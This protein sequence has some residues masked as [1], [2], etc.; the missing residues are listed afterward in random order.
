MS[1][2]V[3]ELEPITDAGP[4]TNPLT[5]EE[6]TQKIGAQMLIK[7]M[8]HLFSVEELWRIHEFCIKVRKDR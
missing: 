5:N 8:L 1:D 6:V 2:F 3:G 4:Y 7:S